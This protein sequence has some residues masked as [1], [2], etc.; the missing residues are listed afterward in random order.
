MT[1]SRRQRSIAPASSRGPRP[2]RLSAALVGLLALAACQKGFVGT[3]RELAEA[4]ARQL[5]EA[6]PMAA[7]D[8]EQAR[9]LCAQRLTESTLLR[10]QLNDPFLWGQQED[11]GVPEYKDSLTRFAPLVWRRLYLS[12]YMFPAE[13]RVEDGPNGR[14]HLHLAAKFR[15][16]LD[17]GSYPYPFWHKAGKWLAYS[18]AKE[19]VFAIE[20][21]R[22]IGAVRSWEGTEGRFTQPPERPE[23]VHEWGGQWTW[24]LG[25]EEY[26]KAVLFSWLLSSDNPHR[27]ALEEAYRDLEFELRQTSCMLCHSP[28]NVVLMP[29]LELFSYPN[30]A[31]TGRHR[32]VQTLENNTMPYPDP[33]RGI[34]LSG[35][36]GG[37]EPKRQRLL[38]LARVFARLGDDAMRFEGEQVP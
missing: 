13:H 14:T 11:A 18:N 17:M 38:G 34:P 30:Q 6:C 28:D 32:I 9:S 7:P 15:N 21:G 19:L 22:V 1:G 37:D 35:Y 10:D 5:A 29:Q 24:T 26:P 25:G 16:K 31:L 33:I 20:K 27:E 12:T 4:V 23:V 3:D 8:D 2:I 36:H